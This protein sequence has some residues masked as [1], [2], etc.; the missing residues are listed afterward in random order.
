MRVLRF[1]VL[2]TLVAPSGFG[3][4]QPESGNL[5]IRCA[6]GYQIQV[7]GKLA[8]TCA[9]KAE[10]FLVSNLSAGD[11]TIV[12]RKSG[13]VPGH[14]AVTIQ[15]GT[16]AEL[17][18]SALKLRRRIKYRPREEPVDMTVESP[19]MRSDDTGTPGQ[20]NVELNFVFDGTLAHGRKVYELPLVDFNYG[21]GENLQ[22]KY[23][24]PW[25]LERTTEIDAVGA[26]RSVSA[27]GL[28][29][30]I[31]GVKYRFYD[32]DESGLSLAVYP[33]VEFRTPGAKSEDD[34]GVA[35]GG[36]TWVL[37]LLLTKELEHFAITGNASLEKSTEE[38]TI[39]SASGGLGTRL[40]PH[41]ALLG[42]I[43]GEDL[44]HSDSRR[45]L[46]NVGLRRKI[47]QQQAVG[48]SIGLDVQAGDS[49][50]QTYVLLTYQRF[51]G[52]K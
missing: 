27:H 49:E 46:L 17:P 10:G 3:Q 50:K 51:F 37:P 39:F 14:F 23:E 40:S 52:G 35:S 45:V 21:V 24:V 29:D 22:L 20:G 31:A 41:L 32:N 13:Y 30:S 42:E 2:V 7:D 11:H 6:A 44:N 1:L 48:A 26:K 19:P 28:G 43:G 47:D 38:G 18:V 34:G 9:T 12:V 5:Q 25:I 15:P 33:Q 4:A 8:G 16:T 36:T